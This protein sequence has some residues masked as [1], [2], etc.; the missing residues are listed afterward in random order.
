MD[1]MGNAPKMG[2]VEGREHTGCLL[3]HRGI[4]GR[5][6]GRGEP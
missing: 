4:Q 3:Q 5:L 6:S 1:G 2:H